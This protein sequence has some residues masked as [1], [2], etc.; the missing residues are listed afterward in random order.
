VLKFLL[1][2]LFA[3][4]LQTQAA[5]P[6][7]LR[8]QPASLLQTFQTGKSALQEISRITDFNHTTH[9]HLQQTYAGYK[10]WSA[11]AVIHAGKQKTMNGIIYRDLETDLANSPAYLFQPA[12]AA[13]ALQLA[14]TQWQSQSTNKNPL[15]HTSCELIVYVDQDNKA[16]WAFQTSFT[17][18]GDLPI[19]P[20]YIMDALTFKIYQ[21]WN[22][23]QTLEETNG[24]GFGGNKKVGKFIYDNIGNDLPDLIIERNALTKK[25]LLENTD[26]SARDRRKHDA[27]VQFNCASQDK[28]HQLFWDADEDSVNGAYSPANDALYAGYVIKKMYQDW[29]NI[30]VLVTPADKP[31]LL[32]M[33]VHE[34]VDNAYWDGEQMTFG[35]GIKAFYPLVSIGVAAHEISH[36]F[37]EQHASLI[38]N[39]QSG[40]LNEAFSDMA[41]Q[42]AEFYSVGHNNWQIGAE[43]LKADNAALRYMD[44]PTKDCHGGKPGQQ[45]SVS[46]LKDYRNSLDVHFSS[47]IFNKFFYLLSTSKNWDTR[48]AFGV[49]VQANTSY[50]TPTTTFTEAACGVLS[51]AK[52][53]HFDVTAVNY[54]ATV[55]GINTKEC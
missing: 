33:R 54:A 25:C 11:N 52:D 28:Q 35:D 14:T 46:S 5:T 26:V 31:M 3:I 18:S 9:I 44:E 4:S 36:G 43:I 1:M 13:H 37:T 39:G 51:A 21:Q 30:P 22:N 55:V 34:N 53:Y 38:Y 40:G 41:A 42:A 17:A 2:L 10:V 49:M 48:K 19:K 12:Q 29:Y 50:W 15:T 27:V 16:H 24:G 6:I 23:I 32:T 47:G 7:N 8:Q 45:C 20:I